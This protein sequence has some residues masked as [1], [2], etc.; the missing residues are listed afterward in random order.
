MTWTHGMVEVSILVMNCSG[1][2]VKSEGLLQ[3]I[4]III[5][6]YSLKVS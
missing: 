5:E 6:E 2:L 1:S 4:T 3:N